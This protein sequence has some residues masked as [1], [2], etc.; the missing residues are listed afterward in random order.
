MVGRTSRSGKDSDG[1]NERYSTTLQSMDLARSFTRLTS[2]LSL[3]RSSHIVCPRS[4]FAAD[5]RLDNTIWLSQFGFPLMLVLLML[6]QLILPRSSIFAADFRAFDILRVGIR[7]VFDRVVSL[8]IHG[9]L[10]DEMAALFGTCVPTR[11]FEVVSLI[12]CIVSGPIP[13]PT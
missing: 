11:C 4:R 2:S 10:V 3:L 5:G 9:F 6:L 8:T 12:Y 13:S 7:A 1:C